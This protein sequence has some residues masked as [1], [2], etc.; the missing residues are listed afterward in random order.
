MTIHKSKGLEFKAVIIPFCDW[1]L[2]KTNSSS[3]LWCKPQPDQQPFAQLPIIPVNYGSKLKD[4]IFADYYW[5]EKL[6]CYIDTLNMTYVAFTRAENELI[7]MAL[8]AKFGTHNSKSSIH[9]F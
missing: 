6:K 2:D 9:G 3:V 1:K 8:K 4:T 7:I 5:S